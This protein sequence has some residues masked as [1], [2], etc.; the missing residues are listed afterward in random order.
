MRAQMY[1]WRRGG[2]DAGGGGHY[3]ALAKIQLQPKLTMTA[4]TR[5]R[6]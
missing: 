6:Q 2:K 1:V 4:R 5:A 3:A